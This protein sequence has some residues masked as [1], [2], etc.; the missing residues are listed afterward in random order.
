MTLLPAAVICLLVYGNSPNDYSPVN[1]LIPFILY[2]G[3]MLLA[4]ATICFCNSCRCCCDDCEFNAMEEN[5]DQY[6]I[7]PYVYD[8]DCH[9]PCS[10]FFEEKSGCLCMSWIFSILL[11]GVGSLLIVLKVTNAATYP[12]TV[13]FI[14]FYILLVF[15]QFA[16]FNMMAEDSCGCSDDCCGVSTVSAFFFNGPL[17]VTLILVN[18]RLESGL[19]G[20][21]VMLPF[22][23]V[24]GLCF[25]IAVVA[26]ICCRQDGD[27]CEHTLRCFGATAF[28]TVFGVW[29][30]MLALW[31]YSRDNFGNVSTYSP[32][33]YSA[34]IPLYI[35]LA[36][37][38]LLFL[39]LTFVVGDKYSEF[40][41]GFASS[42]NY[43]TYPS[44]LMQHLHPSVRPF[45]EELDDDDDDILL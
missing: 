29:F 33:L 38:F 15:L 22:S 10:G 6:C 17:L 30:S 16:F 13:A 37:M 12:V 36:A 14:P 24:V 2:V 4:Q 40:Q 28:L 21:Y 25:I 19:E 35:I 18:V 9:D 11:F 42:A 41:A 23:I 3:Y 5:F 27:C 32:S 39:Y 31:M 43:A 26:C 44:H 1:M 8:S 7:H 45:G 20:Y 34:N